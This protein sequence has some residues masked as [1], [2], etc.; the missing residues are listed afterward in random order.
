MVTTTPV[1]VVVS[2][3]RSG[4]G[5]VAGSSLGGSITGNGRKEITAGIATV[6]HADLNVMIVVVVVIV[7]IIIVAWQ[8]RMRRR[9]QAGQS[10]RGCH[11]SDKTPKPFSPW[12]D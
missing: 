4:T 8:E 6:A 1:V 2:L 5:T 11:A 7:I 12:R 9:V 3:G 10:T